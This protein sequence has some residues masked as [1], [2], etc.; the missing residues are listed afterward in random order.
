MQAQVRNLLAPLY[1]YLQVLARRPEGP[2]P[3]YVPDA[4][5]LERYVAERVSIGPRAFS[6]F[7][8]PQGDDAAILDALVTALRQ[9]LI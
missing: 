3:G 1:G 2:A 9:E 7:S 4:I 5:R 6:A 8:Q